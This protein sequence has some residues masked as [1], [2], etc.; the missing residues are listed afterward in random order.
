[1]TLFADYVN[2]SLLGGIW[3][4][5][6]A[7]VLVTFTRWL[8]NVGVF[9]LAP[10]L[11]YGLFSMRWSQKS[12]LFYAGAFGICLTLVFCHH[13]IANIFELGSLDLTL[14]PDLRKPWA[15]IFRKGAKWGM[16]I[17]ER[18][19]WSCAPTFSYYL[20]KTRQCGQNCPRSPLFLTP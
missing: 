20:R 1:M 10:N 15:G 19:R 13:A 3:P 18:K 12:I 7:A 16:K 9:R 6:P 11:V 5:L 4:R 14:W 17:H 2:M 8:Y